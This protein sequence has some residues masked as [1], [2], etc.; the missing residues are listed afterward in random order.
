MQNVW[1]MLLSTLVLWS[2]AGC[3][4][5]ETDGDQARVSTGD[6]GAAAG[7]A[8]EPASAGVSVELRDGAIAPD[9]VRLSAGARVVLSIENEGTSQHELMIGRQP[10]RGSFLKP[11]FQGVAAEFSGDVAS[12]ETDLGKQRHETGGTD[13]ADARAHYQLAALLGPGES[14]TIT[15]VPPLGHRGE[16]IIGCVFLDHFERGEKGILIVE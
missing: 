8:D 6:S 3:Q 10:A 16:W 5:P 12:A 2:V 7:T 14:A 4:G 1:K 11:F 15:F 9:T 13:H